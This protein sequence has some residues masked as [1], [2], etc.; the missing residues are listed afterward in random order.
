[1]NKMTRRRAIKRATL[2]AGVGLSLLKR[3]SLGGEAPVS[4]SAEPSAADDCFT[5]LRRAGQRH[6]LRLLVL[7][8]GLL[9]KR[10]QR[11]VYAS[12]SLADDVR[13]EKVEPG[14][15]VEGFLRHSRWRMLNEWRGTRPALILIKRDG[16]TLGTKTPEF[17]GLPVEAG[18]VLIIGLVD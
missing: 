14:L 2:L 9:R 3:S 1:M 4:L 12:G 11:G 10:V 15:T 8:E 5:G 6:D 16:I 13:E 17:L 18:D 7:E